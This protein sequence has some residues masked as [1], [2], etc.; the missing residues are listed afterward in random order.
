VTML[1]DDDQYNLERFVAA[2]DAGE[3]FGQAIAE[4]RH[5]RKTSHWMWF[6]FPQI[7]GLGHSPTSRLYAISSL[8]EARAYLAH[9]VLG[10][11]LT[12]CAEIVCGVADRSAEQIFGGIDAQKL[13][14]SATLFALADPTTPVFQRVLDQFFD[15]VPDP[16]TE[17]LS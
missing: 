10:P 6:V 11:R 14:S 13:R 15:G 4:L 9:P 2:Q 3:M 17:E 12:E 16:A 1:S 7:A 8:A 5:G